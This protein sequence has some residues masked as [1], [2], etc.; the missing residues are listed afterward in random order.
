LNNLTQSKVKI[1]R[2]CK[3][4]TLIELIIAVIIL[5][6]LS[7]T[8]APKFFT[9]NGFT[10]FSYRNDVIT[11]LR[12]IQTKAMQQTDSDSCHQ[13][14]ITSTILGTPDNCVSFDTSLLSSATIIVVNNADNITFSTTASGNRFS[15]NSLGRPS[16]GELCEIT[17]TGEQSLTVKIETEGYIHAL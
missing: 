8:V 15:F 4:F 1:L 11:K 9:S 3:G 17:I 2:R 7:A 5:G 16:C 12:L 13:V 6:I 10:E 14:L